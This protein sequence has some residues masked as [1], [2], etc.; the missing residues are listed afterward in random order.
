MITGDDSAESKCRLR[1]ALTLYGDDLCR[2]GD[3]IQAAKV[4][5]VIYM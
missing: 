4:Y 2:A 5:E 3:N 1:L